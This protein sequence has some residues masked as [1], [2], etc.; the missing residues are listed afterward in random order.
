MK[1][2]KGSGKFH[3]KQCDIT[4]ENNVIETF[5]WIKS[6]FKSLHILV[7]NAGFLKMNKIEGTLHD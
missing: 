6:T 3:A 4:I 5:D 2:A 7:N 1:D